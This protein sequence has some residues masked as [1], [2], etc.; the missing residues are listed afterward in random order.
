MVEIASKPTIH[1]D[2]KCNASF[3]RTPTIPR[4][5]PGKQ[6]IGVGELVLL[7]AADKIVDIDSISEQNLKTSLLRD[8]IKAFC[9]FSI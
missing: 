7:Q 3:L 4:K 9:N 6:K 2:A 1:N 5:S 8:L